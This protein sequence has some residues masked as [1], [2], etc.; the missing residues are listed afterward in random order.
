M[1]VPPAELKWL[2]EQPDA[3][4]SNQMQLQDILQTHH[5]MMDARLISSNFSNKLISRTLTSQLGE[6]SG[7]I[8]EEIGSSV[9][10]LFGSAP[11]QYRDVNVFEA[12]TKV[13]AR[14]TNRVF[15]GI[16]LCRNDKLINHL[17]DFSE[18]VVATAFVLRRVPGPLRNTLAPIITFSHNKHRK[19]VKTIV[20]AE[21][22]SRLASRGPKDSTES[23]NDFLQWM[24]DLALANNAPFEL[25][26]GVLAQRLMATNFAALHTSSMTF[27]NAFFD[28]VSGQNAAERMASLRSEAETVF[29]EHGNFSKQ[30]VSQLL[31]IDSAFKESGRLEP[32]TTVSMERRVLKAGGVTTPISKTYIPQGSAVAIPTL[33]IHTDKATYP[34]PH[35]YDPERFAD[36]RATM[37]ATNDSDSKTG[38]QAANLAF[39][40]TSPNIMHFGHGRHACP[41]RF[42]ATQELKVIL[43]Y[44]LLNYD[45][46]PLKE[47][48]ATKTVGNSNFCPTEVKVRVKRRE[49]S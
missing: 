39:S 31:K 26:P 43:A 3:T 46:E 27:T 12:A 21:V 7:A 17:I 44:I 48:P 6:L 15:V 23:R 13:V 24:I 18:S 10:Q 5:T 9:D 28:V 33:M 38:L 4:L 47:R 20:Q 41:G 30:A 34:N 25:E 35:E 29:T 8:Y 16:P 37:N 40:T 1:V 19:A 45:I 22:A 14:T 36:L 42:F 49:K 2:L 11:G 32:L